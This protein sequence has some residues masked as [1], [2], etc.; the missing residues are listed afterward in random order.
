M[1]RA[2]GKKKQAMRSAWVVGAAVLAVQVA[3]GLPARAAPEP[4]VAPPLSESLKGES[5]NDY[6]TA[7]VLLRSRDDVGALIRFTRIY[8]REHDPRLL[9]NMGL[10][11]KDMEHPARA[12]ELFERALRDGAA[13]FSPDQLAQVRQLLNAS[14][15][16]AGRARVT[17][18]V[19]GA[20]VVVD[21]RP[22]GTSPLTTDLLVDRG[23]H[24]VRVSKAGYRDWTRDVAVPE[25][26]VAA[27]DASLQPDVPDGAVRVVTA[28]G[29][30]VAVDGRF[31]SR[32]TGE[33]RV[34]A[35]SHAVRVTGDGRLPFRTDISIRANETRTIEVAL[36]EDRRA[37]VWLWVVGGTVVG[38]AIVV[39]AASVFHPSD[40]HASA[41]S[42][43][44]PLRVSW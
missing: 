7:R 32:G 18:D 1:A 36:Q 2:R 37:P 34:P 41:A 9:A 14:V 15:A 40:A 23:T 12:A 17:V 31:V 27:V 28:A 6:Q 29:N 19:P 21:D 42:V 43:Q 39:A 5:L 10:C 11:E 13:L 44:S 8:D 16:A 24:R 33:A 30:E 35:G 20:A 38:V 4:P 25:A 26:S 22:V 3:A